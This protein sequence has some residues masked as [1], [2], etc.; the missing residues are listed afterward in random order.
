MLGRRLRS[1]RRFR[2]LSPTELARRSSVAVEHLRDAEDGA[3]AIDSAAL[4]ELLAA[5]DVG[6]YELL[7]SPGPAERGGRA[8]TQMRPSEDDPASED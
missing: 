8:I 6:L 7:T 3:V 4:T 2:G 1:W 5:L